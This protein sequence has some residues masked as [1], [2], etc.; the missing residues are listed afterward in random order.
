M[1]NRYEY[2]QQEMMAI[3]QLDDGFYKVDPDGITLLYG[4]FYV[5]NAEYEL[6]RHLSDTYLYPVGG[7]QWF[8]SEELARVAFSLPK[9][10]TEE[11]ILAEKLEQLA[12]LKQ[13]LGLL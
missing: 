11:E 3:S 4:R 1:D 6:H 13:E 2:T 8:D 9:P 7:W 10:P 5:L 12:A